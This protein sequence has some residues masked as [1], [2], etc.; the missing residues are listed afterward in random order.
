MTRSAWC[1]CGLLVLASFVYGACLLTGPDQWGR[2]DWD[3]FT[4]RFATPRPAMLRD[5][6]LPLW[7]PYVN[8]GN[9]LLAH[10]HCPAFSPW[11][12]LTLALG[13]PWGLRLGVVLFVALGTTGMAALL[14]RW[15]VSAAGCFIG[16]VVLM[17]SAHFTMHVTEGH[18]EW[19]AL[20]LI[21]WVLWCLVRAKDDWRFVVFGA[22]V[23][24]SGWLYGSIYIV[25]I[26]TPLLGI[27]A[28]LESVRT[29]SWRTVASYGVLTALTLLLCAV[30][31]FPRLEFLQA[32]P[33][34]TEQHEQVAPAMLPRMWL[35]PGQAALY[36]Q[37]RDVRNPSVDELIRLLP[38][39]SLS[40]AKPYETLKWHR[41]E[42]TLATTSDWS[43]V[44]FAD[45]EH[46]LFY[47]GP[48]APDRTPARLSSLPPS[49][50]VLGIENPQ[51]GKLA[52]RQATVYLQLPEQGAVNCVVNRHAAGASRLTVRRGKDVLLDAIHADVL[53]RSRQ[54]WGVFCIRREAILGGGPGE[55]G[56]AA[57]WVR[58]D[59]LVNTTAD[60][61]KVEV[62]NCPYLF[63][64]E[65][66]QVEAETRAQGGPRLVTTSLDVS[67][68]PPGESET[69]RRANL[70][71][72]VPKDGDVRMAVTQGSTGTTTLTLKTPEGKSLETTHTE[73]TVPSGEKTRDYVLSGELIRR[74]L[75]PV[76]KPMR[77]QLDELGMTH[78]W[79][80]YGCYV[81]WL[82][83]AMAALGLVVSF[84]RQWPLVA[85]GVV[86]GLVVMGAGLP[87]NFWA[88][89]KLLPMYGS[90]QVPSR[91]LVAVL[92]AAAVCSGYG[93]DRIGRWSQRVGGA[94]LRRLVEFGV[95][96]VIYVELA[97]LG[98]ALFSEI[99]V[100]PKQPPP[101][102]A[103]KPFSQRFAEDEARYAAMYSAHYPYLQDNSGVLR[104][105]ENIAIPR[106]KIRLE[107]DPDYRGEAYLEGA[108][109]GARIL[110][111]TMSRVNVAVQT[112]TPD[113]LVLNQNYFPGWKA[114]RRN[115]AGAIE[116]LPAERSP[117][118]LVS[119]AV[120]A[121]DREVVFYY[122][123]DVF[124]W[125]AALSGVT[126]LGC[127][128][129]LAVG[130]GTS[131]PARTRTRL[132]ARS[133]LI[134]SALRQSRACG[135]VA[136][137]VAL[138][139]PF[140]LCHP[141]WTLVDLPLVRSLAV[142]A[143]L[144]LVPG[145][146]LVGALIGRGWL[147]RGSLLWPMFGSLGVLA[148]AIVASHLVGAAADASLAWNATWVLTNL[149]IVLNVVAGGPPGCGIQWRRNEW[150]L[151]VGLFAVAYLLFFV[152]AT[153][154]VPSMQDHDLDIQGPGY[155]LLTRFEPKVVTDR[156]TLYYFAHPL[157]LNY[158][159]AASLLYFDQLDYLARFDEATSRAELAESGVPVE[160]VVRQFRRLK[161]HRLVR[162]LG[163]F[164][165]GATR[166]RI[167]GQRRGNYVIEPPLPKGTDLLPARELEVQI[168]YDDYHREPRRLETRT[169]NIFLAAMT[170]A[171]LGC[172][173][174]RIAGRG[175]FAVLAAS[176]Y[177]TSP[178]V[179]VRSSYGGFFAITT[180][181][182]VQILLAVE[183]RTSDRSRAAWID[184]LLAG[185]FAALAN[186][187]LILLPAALVVWEFF[188]IERVHVGKRVVKAM[189]HPVVVGFALGTVAFW[190]YGLAIHAES[191]WVDYV[192]MHGVD[193]M[194]HYNPFNYQ[195]Y[196]TVLGLWLEFWGHTGYV[197]L[198]L[199]VAALAYLCATRN[200]R[201]DSAGLDEAKLGWR[202]APGLWVLWVLLVAVVFSL[203]DWRQT[204][205]LMPFVPVLYLAAARWA[206]KNRTV[207]AVAGVL[208]ACLLVWNLDMLR[209]LANDFRAFPI[210]PDW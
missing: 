101:G 152:G 112:D 68:R 124:L 73:T 161:D 135:Y 102:P 158:Y 183:R 46:L 89:W 144:M 87:V 187:K 78:D 39:Q 76:P 123:P 58:L 126:L 96:S 142:G 6:Q 90:L 131:G 20:G 77:W 7:N 51:P 91:F 122:L 12:L 41:L 130:G 49:G 169:P 107:H 118:G 93:V 125:G 59:V 100:C 136:M 42:V 196:P 35:D 26:F 103:G 69:T 162:D 173:I 30:V 127:L 4:F 117:E 114:A 206:G 40:T 64:M 33:R 95:A 18:L 52:T 145:L 99:F 120:D 28:V 50:G 155:A 156:N 92:F 189:V 24:A 48:D 32:N 129:A 8:G 43:E 70:Y 23:L 137:A 141:G 74:E 85:V 44:R 25:A 188:R 147:S 84:R 164:Q 83:L 181:A 11:Y 133:L 180:F 29:G 13:A 177:F 186:N 205:H 171:L 66:P 163:E 67:G 138:N 82:G 199:G 128:L 132:A 175:W 10:P 37:T 150:P 111:W 55:V 185:G 202:G 53:P 115:T 110:Q 134:W 149:A 166:H 56:S 153:R 61:C 140:L 75:S 47:D 190:V 3:Q 159:E 62:A 176:A 151:A 22:L 86:A 9:V 210:T 17:M 60:W 172:W 36:R 97:V 194:T 184:C 19:C 15:N 121:D 14:R 34:K 201:H 198:P 65:S 79:H 148:M 104:E 38:A 200:G 16:G 119:I 182:M 5:G 54:H 105:Y 157:L 178:E 146:P 57:D 63:Q 154:T 167:V 209:V 207:L 109:A 71:V 106:G 197:L 72:Q 203:I 81:T 116:R 191:F 1:V 195:G 204:K 98:W 27:W 143:V 113:R 168:L 179:F 139:L 31:L 192:R 165:E 108:D 2:A 174:L 80:E 160:P 21:P 170:V 193:R 45:V 94:W 208:F 88:L